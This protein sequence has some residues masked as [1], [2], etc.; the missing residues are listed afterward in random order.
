MAE[1]NTVELFCPAKLNLALSVG[2]ADP[3]QGGLHPLVSWMVALDYGDQLIVSRADGGPSRFDMSFDGK[4]AGDE[5]PWPLDTD[6]TFR[7]H[8]L[9]SEHVGRALDVNVVVHKHIL[10]G[11]GLGGGSANAAGMMVA[12]NQLFDLGMDAAAL[13]R[14]GIQLGSDVPFVVGALTG[15]TSAVVGGVGEQL[16]TARRTDPIHL[17]L[18]IPPFG[19]STARVYAAFD[20]LFEPSK[21]PDLRR[22]RTLAAQP[23]ITVDGP[24][25]DLAEPACQVEPRLGKARDRV[26]AACD[27]PVHIT[28][29][30]SAMFV[31]APD[32]PA[33]KTL[34]KHIGKQTGLQ[35]IATRT[36]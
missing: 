36:I 17:A 14:L 5:R 33:A 31:L 18:A 11:A 1:P 27:L 15:A 3:S 32:A 7:A 8:G 30:G 20:E 22:V 4:P 24:F 16:E 23:T 25:N 9:L 28:G 35:T 21:Q 2:A 6:L 12:L 26:A 29:S 19:C 13:Q 34:A 10:P